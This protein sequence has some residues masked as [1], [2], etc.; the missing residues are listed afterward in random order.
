MGCGASSGV[1]EAPV[2]LDAWREKEE[3][4]VGAHSSGEQDSENQEDHIPVMPDVVHVHQFVARLSVS[5]V[6]NIHSPL[7]AGWH[8]DYQVR[9]TRAATDTLFGP[10][11]MSTLFRFDVSRSFSTWEDAQ[12]HTLTSL[13]DLAV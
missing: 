2:Q 6:T 12:I 3:R 5:P 7:D 9:S 10:M 1:S 13:D 11:S 4:P 8:D